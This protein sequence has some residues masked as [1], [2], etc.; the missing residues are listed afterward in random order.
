MFSREGL[1]R[2]DTQISSQDVRRTTYPLPRGVSIGGGPPHCPRD[3][4]T[5]TVP[6]L[7][8]EPWYENR[9]RGQGLFGTEV[10]RPRGTILPVPLPHWVSACASA[11]PGHPTSSTSRRPSGK[12]LPTEF[13]SELA[14]GPYSS[15]QAQRTNRHK[16]PPH[17]LA[18]EALRSTSGSNLCLSRRLSA[19]K[20]G[21][22]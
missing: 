19:R 5:R 2:E 11:M 21:A 8:Y 3:N 15:A 20:R 10:V 14:S 4:T 1:A 17:P 16:P 12:P 9:K 6:Q 18:T 7:S 22:I 13:S